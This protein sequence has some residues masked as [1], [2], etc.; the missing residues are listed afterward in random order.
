[1]TVEISETVFR[2]LIA[3]K[4][5]LED[6][7]VLLEEGD[8]RMQKRRLVEKLVKIVYSDRYGEGMYH[9]EQ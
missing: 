1:M 3:S 7:K 5:K 9:G 6:I 4:S 8:P 2:D